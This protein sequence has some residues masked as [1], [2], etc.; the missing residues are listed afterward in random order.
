MRRN[1]KKRLGTAKPKEGS[2]RDLKKK[3]KSITAQ[4]VKMR[5]GHQCQQCSEDN[6]I[7]TG[8]IDAGHVYPVSAFPGGEFDLTNIHGQ[9][10]RHN[11]IHIG[12]PELYLKWFEN[13]FGYKELEALHERALAKPPTNDELRVMIQERTAK[14]EGLRLLA[15]A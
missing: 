8:V 6:V 13:K 11:T 5:D 7:S 3:C 1:F 12:R 10:R 2:R 4:L 9:C 14:V 15:V